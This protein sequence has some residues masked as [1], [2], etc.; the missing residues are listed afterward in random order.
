MFAYNPPSYLHQAAAPVVSSGSNL[1]RYERSPPPIQRTLSV[2]VRTSTNGEPFSQDVTLT[3]R[4][5]PKEAL[6]TA[7]GKEKGEFHVNKSRADESS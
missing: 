6:V 4:Q 1:R 5:Q 2:T 7:E 3:L